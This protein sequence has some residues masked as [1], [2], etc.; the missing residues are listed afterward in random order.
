MYTHT[1]ETS[2]MMIGNIA[3]NRKIW[4]TLAVMSFIASAIGAIDRNIYDSVASTETMSGI[5][6]QDLMTI[7]ASIAV[8]ILA[9]RMKKDDSARQLTAVGIT[10][11]LFYAYGIYVI[12]Q[13]YTPLYFLYMAIFGLSFYSILYCLLS[14]NRDTTYKAD[15]SQKVRATSLAFLAITPAIFYPLWMAQLV[16]LIQNADKVEFLY[17]IYI[18]DI[19]F[20]MPA[21]I[22]AA[23]KVRKKDPLA[24][25]L[26]PSLFVLGFTLLFPLSLV[27][28][29][30]PAVYNQQMDPAGMGLFLTLSA[31]YAILAFLNIRTI[32]KR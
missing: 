28:M 31:I 11:Y 7:A 19:C 29:L 21:F 15:I 3:N 12:E 5:L 9:F 20:I 4:G 8:L 27:E 24:T 14:L 26:S 18:L 10:G 23:Y 32:N 2:D 25:A 17:S 30:K 13:L 16:P 22:I 1:K 6:A